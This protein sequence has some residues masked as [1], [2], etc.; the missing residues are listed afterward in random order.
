M[1]NRMRV[2]VAAALV[3]A[4]LAG[5]II[6]AEW[7]KVQPVELKIIKYSQQTQMGS[8]FWSG[9]PEKNTIQIEACYDYNL[10][11]NITGYEI[12]ISR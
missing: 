12:K 6:G 7:Q 11:N 1:Q 8:I 3:V 9:L 5:V 4:L 2:L 10:K